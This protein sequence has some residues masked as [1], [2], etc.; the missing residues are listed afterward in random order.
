MEGRRDRILSL[1][2]CVCVC[3]CVCMC[4]CVCVHVCLYV[5]VCVRV[6]YY[7]SV[8]LFPAD[9]AETSVKQCRDRFNSRKLA[10]KRGGKPFSAEFIVADCARVS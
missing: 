3:V 1:C 6:C 8:D 5:H 9:I 10:H 7:D 4:V 2:W